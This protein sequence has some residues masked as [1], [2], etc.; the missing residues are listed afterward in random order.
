MYCK[1]YYAF[2]KNE[3]NENDFKISLTNQ[4]AAIQFNESFFD[5]LPNEF[6]R[7]YL[8]SQCPSLLKITTTA[9]IS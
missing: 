8:K 4:I 6:L 2:S 1:L 5:L 7:D 9:T 3:K